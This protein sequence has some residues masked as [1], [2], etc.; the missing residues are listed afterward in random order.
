MKSLMASILF[1]L[2]VWDRNVQA[3]ARLE[4]LNIDPNQIS[5]SGVSSGAMM[6]VQL[7]VIYSSWIHGMGSIAGGV[8]ACAENNPLR[9]VGVCMKTPEQINVQSILSRMM[10]LAKSGQIDPLEFP[11]RIGFGGCTD[12]ARRGQISGPTPSAPRHAHRAG[13]LVG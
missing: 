10:T 2:L 12:A 7:N 4:R 9:A 3:A 11:H 13:R 8:F 1:L 6:A 5:V